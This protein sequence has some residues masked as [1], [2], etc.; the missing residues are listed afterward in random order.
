MTSMKRLFSGARGWNA[1]CASQLCVKLFLIAAA[2]CSSSL[3]LEAQSAPPGLQHR[4]SF[5]ANGN[6]SV[7]TA[8]GSL[9]GGANVGGG[10]LVL[11][12]A[13][14]YLDLPNNLL[15]GYTAVSIEVWM[16]DSGSSPWARIWD[17]GN[18]SG[19]EGAGGTGTNY[20]FL[21]LPPGAGI[22]RCAFTPENSSL[23]QR[24]D[25]AGNRPPVGQPAHLV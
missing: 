9:F 23:E 7:G 20:M 18:S 5:S 13:G 15:T 12:G 3:L 17:F 4:Y 11:P 1:A 19:G 25:W 2:L 8:H 6:D 24:V 22:L 16:T 21:S 10:A 14:S